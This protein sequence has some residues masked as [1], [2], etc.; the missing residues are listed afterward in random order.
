MLLIL[1]NYYIFIYFMALNNITF[2][3]ITVLLLGTGLKASEANHDDAE[4]GAINSASSEESDNDLLEQ[5]DEK[6]KINGS[7]STLN[8][9]NGD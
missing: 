6:D 9:D 1:V 7:N 3:I 2:V 5:G 8:G 4:K